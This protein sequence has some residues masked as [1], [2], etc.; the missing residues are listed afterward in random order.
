MTQIHKKSFQKQTKNNHDH[1][2]HNILQLIHVLY[3]TAT[4]NLFHF[5]INIDISVQFLCNFSTIHLN[6]LVF[7]SIK[8]YVSFLLFYVKFIEFGLI[9]I[10]LH[11][12]LVIDIKNFN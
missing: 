7:D 2:T 9:F 3:I 10:K 6:K 11:S 1:Q 12:I 4:I 5:L 8:R